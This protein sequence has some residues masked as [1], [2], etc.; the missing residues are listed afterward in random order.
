[1]NNKVITLVLCAMLLA[2][3]GFVEAQQ[4]GKIFRMGILDPSTASGSAVLLEAFR[5]ELNKLG[6]I[7]GKNIAIEYRFAEGNRDRLP[8]VALELARLPVDLIVT[9]GPAGT[10]TVKEA[11]ITIPIVMGFDNDPVG[12]G[13]VASL[14]RPGGNITGLSTLSPEISGKQLE[15]LKEIIPKL[16]RVAVLGNSTEPGN[17]QAL[18]ELEIAAGAFRLQLH[19]LDVKKDQDIETGF[20]AATRESAHAVLLL[21]SP[22]VSARR[23]RIAAVAAK[24]RLP[25]I[26]PWPEF[27]QDGGLMSYGA[28][29]TDLFRRAAVM[30]DKILKGTKPA[31]IPVEQP[32]KFEFVINLKTAKQ[33][34][35]TIPPNVLARADKVIK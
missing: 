27:V 9:G 5:Q 33:I 32:T 2:L 19:Y 21:G 17:A 7:E 15:L 34:G 8:K 13:F 25:T 12:S 28:S 6:W 20:R 30:V 16:S 23:T 4:P 24:S 10:R 18:K 29:I 35:V 3:C 31:D 26:Y 14:A 22:V 1:M 11:N